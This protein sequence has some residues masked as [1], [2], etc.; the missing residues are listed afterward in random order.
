M[1]C[2]YCKQEI[3][4]DSKMCQYCGKE[5]IFKNKSIIKKITD[6]IIYIM[7]FIFLGLIMACIKV[8]YQYFSTPKMTIQSEDTVKKA[9]F[10]RIFYLSNTEALKNYCM[11]TGYIPNTFI[12]LF[13]LSFKESLQNADNIL[14]KNRFDKNELNNS[15]FLNK[16]MYPEYEKDYNNIKESYQEKHTN[17]YTKKDY[18]MSYDNNAEIMVRAKIEFFKKAKPDLYFDKI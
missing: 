12:N 10:V 7:I 8:G 13:S 11:D 9:A 5:I 17:I 16:K 18:C 14:T 4:N 15:S 6:V 1:L 2:P 3:D